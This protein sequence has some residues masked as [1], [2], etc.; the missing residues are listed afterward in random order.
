MT[1][2][3]E[4]P[5]WYLALLIG[6]LLNIAMFM[7]LPSLGY[8]KPV[9]DIPTVVVDF[10]EWR[11]PLPT[12]TTPV[13]PVKP[14]EKPLPK[15]KPVIKREAVKPEQIKNEVKLTEQSIQEQSTSTPEVVEDI[16]E[17]KPIVKPSPLL[18]KQTAQEQLPTPVPVFKLTSMPRFV[19]RA[20][21]YPP[22]MQS[23]GK[24]AVVKLEA[25]IDKHGNVRQVRIIESAGQD[26]DQAAIES[27]KASTFIPGN[28]EGKPVAVLLRIPVVFQLR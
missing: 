14:V 13:P 21:F 18:D 3:L 23:M 9:M 20:Q 17:P 7:L 6:S 26:F 19:H 1:R 16:P 10:M 24:E 2:P 22:A 11:E 27:I 28:V 25:L 4:Y 15:T 8:K 5:Y 12:P